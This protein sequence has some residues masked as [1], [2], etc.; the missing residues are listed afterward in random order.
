LLTRVEVRT[1]QGTLLNFPLDDVLN[2]Y[3]IE[4]IEGLDPVKATLVTSTDAGQDGEQDHGWRR[5][6]RDIKLKIS[7]EP[8][9]VTTTVKNLRD[10]LYAYFMT[11][12]L[13][14]LRFVD[15]DDSEYDI[16]GRVESCDTPLFVKEPR[17]D[18]SVHCYNPDFVIP[19]PI[20]LPGATVETPIHT[21]IDYPGTVDTGL[22]VTI[23]VNR[24]ESSFSIYVVGEDEMTRQLDFSAPLVAG[25][26]VR[27]STVSG[28]KGATLKRAGVETSALY[29]V[30][31]TSDWVT[32]EQGRNKFR[33]QTSGA[34]I[35]YTLEYLTRFGGL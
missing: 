15:D 32:L 19:A 12:R 14:Y 3:I 9:Y 24:V 18:V 26:I 20:S 6:A 7:L 34:P 25:D 17:V 13:V 30:D 23:P 4:E 1:R 27:I 28:A 16:V 5:E 21:L 2:G 22:V 33:V 8:D 10:R 11:G 35:P 29:G 31:P